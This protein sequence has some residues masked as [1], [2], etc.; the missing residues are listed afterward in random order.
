MHHHEA[1]YPASF[2]SE[3]IT[4]AV[5]IFRGGRA[6]IVSERQ[7]LGLDIFNV[8]G[9]AQRVFIG[10]PDEPHANFGA[11]NEAEAGE[12]VQELCA[13]S[14]AAVGLHGAEQFGA[15]DWRAALKWFL[16]NIVPLILPLIL[17]DQT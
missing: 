2:P 16:A 5:S 10:V 11:V 1:S 3:C 9:Y 15:V 12:Q 8:Q 17:E 7:T 6:S 13:T 14:S 4:S